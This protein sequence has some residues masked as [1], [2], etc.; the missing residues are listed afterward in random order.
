[1]PTVGVSK[2]LTRSAIRIMAV[3]ASK[4]GRS[5]L[6]TGNLEGITAKCYNFPDQAA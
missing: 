6:N 5:V 3:L 4:V 2:S 1:M